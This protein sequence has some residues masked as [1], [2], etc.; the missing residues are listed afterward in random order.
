MSVQWTPSKA[1]IGWKPSRYSVLKL[2]LDSRSSAH[3]QILRLRSVGD[4]ARSYLQAAVFSQALTNKWYLSSQTIRPWHFTLHR[5]I[6]DVV[7]RQ[8]WVEV[9]IHLWSCTS[10]LFD[11]AKRAMEVLPVL[12]W[13]AVIDNKIDVG[14]E[15]ITPCRDSIILQT[16][17][18]FITWSNVFKQA[19]VHSFHPYPDFE[20]PILLLISGPGEI[21]KTSRPVISSVDWSENGTANEHRVNF[22]LV[23]RHHDSSVEFVL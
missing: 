17:S 2:H 3:P 19:K 18:I 4:G 9:D 22:W 8:R 11:R 16:I 15:R 23:E 14:T 5:R 1:V 7:F 21:T 20:A 10:W 12:A 13:C 6:F